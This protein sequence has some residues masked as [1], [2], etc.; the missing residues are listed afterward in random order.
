VPI[1]KL[2]YIDDSENNPVFG[3]GKDVTDKNKFWRYGHNNTFINDPSGQNHMLGGIHFA[4]DYLKFTF[5]LSLAPNEYLL[6]MM[7][8]L[9]LENDLADRTLFAKFEP[10]EWA[11]EYREVLY[12]RDEFAP[13]L[14][15]QGMM[16]CMT[17]GSCTH[18]DTNCGAK[19]PAFWDELP[20]QNEITNG[21]AVFGIDW[22]VPED[23]RVIYAGIFGSGS[24]VNPPPG[25]NVTWYRLDYTYAYV[26]DGKPYSE[27]F[28][29]GET[30]DLKGKTLVQFEEEDPLRPKITHTFGKDTVLPQTVVML[31]NREFFD[32]RTNKANFTPRTDDT[33]ETKL[34]SE[35]Y[36]FD[37]GKERFLDNPDASEEELASKKR[38]MA[39]RDWWANYNEKNVHAFTTVGGGDSGGGE[40]GKPAIDKNYVFAEDNGYRRIQMYVQ[41]AANISIDYFCTICEIL[42]CRHIR[43]QKNVDC[44]IGPSHVHDNGCGYKPAFVPPYDIK[45]VP[46]TVSPLQHIV[47]EDRE[48]RPDG[49]GD[50]RGVNT[51]TDNNHPDIL[52][53]FIGWQYFDET[54]REDDRVLP[55]FQIN[56]PVNQV[57]LAVFVPET[58]AIS[59]ID[60]VA[61]TSL[62]NPVD[63]MKG[64]LLNRDGNMRDITSEVR[65]REN[66]EAN[67]GE[68]TGS[69]DGYDGRVAGFPANPNLLLHKRHVFGGWQSPTG[70]R[71]DFDGKG[72]LGIDGQDFTIEDDGTMILLW[73]A[74]TKPLEDVI[75]VLRRDVRGLDSD[76]VYAGVRA[77][78]SRAWDTINEI[79]APNRTATDMRTRLAQNIVDIGNRMWELD[80]ACLGIIDLS[81]SEPPEDG[82]M[83]RIRRELIEYRTVITAYMGAGTADDFRFPTEGH[84]L[85]NIKNGPL[86]LPGHIDNQWSDAVILEQLQK[87]C[88]DT[89]GLHLDEINNLVGDIDAKRIDAERLEIWYGGFRERLYDNFKLMGVVNENGEISL[90]IDL[91]GNTLREFRRE[92]SIV[93]EYYELLTTG[94]RDDVKHQVDGILR[95]MS[96]TNPAPTLKTLGNWES[97][98]KTSIVNAI[99]TDIGRNITDAE[100]WPMTMDASESARERGIEALELLRESGVTL[101]NTMVTNSRN[102]LRTGIHEVERRAITGLDVYDMFYKTIS[103]DGTARHTFYEHSPTKSAIQR[104][105]VYRETAYSVNGLPSINQVI[106]LP[107][108]LPGSGP[109]NNA[110]LRG[111]I[112]RNLQMLRIYRLDPTLGQQDA[113]RLDGIIAEGAKLYNNNTW[114][115]GTTTEARA[116][117]TASVK[118]ARESGHE[119]FDFGN[120]ANIDM[121]H[122]LYGGASSTFGNLQSR[123]ANQS[124]VNDLGTIIQ[125]LEGF[126]NAETPNFTEGSTLFIAMD[127]ARKAI[128]IPTGE[129]IAGEVR[130]DAGVALTQNEVLWHKW[131]VLSTLANPLYSDITKDP[132]TFMSFSWP[133]EHVPRTEESLRQLQFL[134]DVMGEF[135]ELWENRQTTDEYKLFVEA[136]EDARFIIDNNRRQEYIDHA[137]TAMTGYIVEQEEVVNQVSSLPLF[138]EVDG[139]V[140]IVRPI[141]DNRAQR[142]YLMTII[143]ILADYLPSS[144]ISNDFHDFGTH[145]FAQRSG[146][147]AILR[148]QVTIARN[149]LFVTEAEVREAV[150][151]QGILREAKELLVQ[152]G[153]VLALLH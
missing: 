77:A 5:D 57:L 48:P 61:G 153:G 45:E 54:L 35:L 134:I 137:I 141:F 52:Y 138:E 87:H 62:G 131:N 147:Q 66:A 104:T 63:G 47:Y 86:P 23:E 43:G 99:E 69:H 83:L 19:S 107:T 10:I 88:F 64:A 90:D 29:D 22:S 143:N 46:Y 4:D 96:L 95:E 81:S 49:L 20:P 108:W 24:F 97:T 21:T 73:R 129:R 55:F 130:F 28:H 114:V 79:N 127:N 41:W 74:N 30:G 152:S 26:E 111:A 117:L 135:L 67:K 11:I 78:I 18:W 101:N 33:R 140:R 7:Q 139:E 15:E 113:N 124:Y 120:Q 71:L 151:R 56:S 2:D 25:H 8:D 145:I 6:E 105:Y 14:T 92:L 112:T 115:G 65:N 93:E 142:A 3:P 149:E 36:L 100:G 16:A 12:V 75:N 42:N 40:P 123:E 58:F 122:A 59:F 150:T 50:V 89:L 119:R 109:I 132:R 82:C 76:Q 126:Y 125:R 106:V 13:K 51:T 148:N 91:S 32:E 102:R 39:L 44:A 60:S 121:A 94:R 70:A 128:S 144:V 68:F 146:N 34:A 103:T 116:F 80:Q 72:N 9:V 98:V 133:G 110:E 118:F 17:L 53:R 38:S 85:A 1:V 27:L 136:I 37:N 84:Y 31:E